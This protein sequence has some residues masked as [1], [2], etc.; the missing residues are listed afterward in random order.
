MLCTTISAF[1]EFLGYKSLWQRLMTTFHNQTIFS[2]CKIFSIR[3][4]LLF[5]F[6]F[7]QFTVFYSIQTFHS[8]TYECYGFRFGSALDSFS[9][10]KSFSCFHFIRHYNGISYSIFCHFISNIGDEARNLLTFHTFES[11]LNVE[12]NNAKREEI[13]QQKVAC[14][15]N[16]SD[17][18]PGSFHFFYF[19]FQNVRT[20]KCIP[21]SEMKRFYDI[22]EMQREKS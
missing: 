2:S 10:L 19:P 22:Q 9:S 11:W 15:Q 5:R 3:R 14:E 18:Y 4:W 1:R 21:N 12:R 17:C 8:F 13:K 6:M 7:S 16:Q 20:T